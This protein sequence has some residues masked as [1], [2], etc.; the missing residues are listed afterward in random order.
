[1][2]NTICLMLCCSVLYAG[3]ANREAN[4]EAPKVEPK[5]DTAGTTYAVKYSDP[6]EYVKRDNNAIRYEEARRLISKDKLPLLHEMLED[7]TYAPYRHNIAELIG[8][9]SDDPTS[10][11]VLFR[12]FQS[13]ESGNISSLFIK[14]GAIKWI[15]KIGGDEADLI[16]RKAVTEQGAVNLAEWLDDKPWPRK[17]MK[18]KHVIGFIRQA[19]MTGLV[20]TGKAENIRLVEEIY[21]Q[22][23]P[24]AIRTKK[25]TMVFGGAIDALA[26]KDFIAENGLEAYLSLYGNNRLKKLR[27]YLR[28]YMPM[29]PPPP[30]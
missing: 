8:Y 4:P 1:M 16:L 30:K 6:R 27:P 5:V 11:P 15:G 12:Y 7:K 25:A 24:S 13:N 20:L 10:V 23:L 14:P 19:A 3:C 2:K 28:K 29:P 21:E 9:I 18:R 26:I 17:G 22:E